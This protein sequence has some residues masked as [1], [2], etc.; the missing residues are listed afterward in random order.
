MEAEDVRDPEKN[1]GLFA[2]LAD[3]LDSL[4]RS[5]LHSLSGQEL[6]FCFRKKIPQAIDIHITNVLSL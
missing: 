4:Y 2:V 3:S 5:F 1:R 6:I